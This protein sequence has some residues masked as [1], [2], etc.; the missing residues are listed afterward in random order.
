MT[1]THGIF[2]AKEIHGLLLGDVD[3][4]L[5]G[6]DAHHRAA[7]NWLG[8]DHWQGIADGA[9]SDIDFEW[10]VDSVHDFS[11]GLGSG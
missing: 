2:E 10:L 11:F 7:I 8:W 9:H 6:A 3:D 5:T 1:N 4:A